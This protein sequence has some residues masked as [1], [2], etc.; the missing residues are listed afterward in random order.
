MFVTAT[1]LD[2]VFLKSI[3]VEGI[4]GRGSHFTIPEAEVCIYAGDSQ[5]RS[6]PGDWYMHP[7]D[8]R[9]TK[10]WQT[11]GMRPLASVAG[12]VNGEE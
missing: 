8:V 5:W 11:E 2:K 12:N 7:P 4:E 3:F 1:R 6:C 10:R 9:R